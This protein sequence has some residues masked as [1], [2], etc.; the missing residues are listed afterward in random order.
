LDALNRMEMLVR[1]EGVLPYELIQ[2]QL[3][4]H[5]DCVVHMA[6]TPQGQRVIGISIMVDRTLKRLW[7][8]VP[9]KRIHEKARS[10]SE[11]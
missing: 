7:T 1:G 2:N 10:L 6:S 11:V 3:R 5:L 4:A 9:Q 8:W